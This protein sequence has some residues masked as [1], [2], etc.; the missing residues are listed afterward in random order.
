M[1]LPT[2]TD[3]ESRT[4][5]M[6]RC[7]ADPDMLAEYDEDE[8]RAAVCVSQWEGGKAKF[9]KHRGYEAKL[10]DVDR[11]KRTLVWRISTDT[12]DRDREVILPKG[13]KLDRFKQNPRVLWSHDYSMP[14]IAKALWTKASASELISK[15]QFVAEGKYPW[16]NADFASLVFEM[17]AD[18][19]MSTSSVGFIPVRGREPTEADIKARPDWAGTY[20][21]HEEVDLLEYSAVAVPSN[22]D[23][24]QLACKGMKLDT[25]SLEALGLAKTDHAYGICDCGFRAPAPYPTA[26][27]DCEQELMGSDETP[28]PVVR[29]VTTAEAMQEYKDAER[30]AAAPKVV[31]LG[32]MEVRQPITPV[33]TPE[34]KLT[35][36]PAQRLQTPSPQAPPVEVTRLQR[37]AALEAPER[38]VT[39]LSKP[40]APEPTPAKVRRLAS[41]ADMV[42][43]RDAEAAAKRRGVVT[44]IPA[45]QSGQ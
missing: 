44:F 38:H 15:P 42:A 39:R 4:D 3:G 37:P 21:I 11:E 24:V 7:N 1:P 27:P 19:N 2:P 13:V 18:G 10:E 14:P 34:P 6:A 36:F 29:G 35:P 28:A 32:R 26:C 43:Q 8:Q 31:R 41:A 9:A 5:F 12:Q 33:A 23:A 16:T 22:P 30:Q 20:Y 17:Y 25:P 40:T 45:D